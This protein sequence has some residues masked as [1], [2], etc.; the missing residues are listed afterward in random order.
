MRWIE[1]AQTDRVAAL[2]DF[3]ATWYADVPRRAGEPG[4]AN[5]GD[6]TVPPPLREFFRAAAGRPV[7]H[8]VQN[9][10]RPVG[11]LIPDADGWVPF[12]DENQ[13]AFILRYGPEAVDPPVRCHD[14]RTETAEGEPLS[15]VLLQ[16]V[17]SEAAVGAPAGGSGWLGP[18]ALRRLTSA[19]LPVPLTPAGWIGGPVSVHA[20]PGLVVAVG[21]ADADGDHHVFAGARHRS[22]LGRLRQLDLPWEE[23]DG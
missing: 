2:C 19:L 15:G 10:I 13:G 4:D 3:V 7:V 9:S 8:G 12:A 23:F 14:G 17:L 22:G 16:F 6:G 1:L 20:G 21:A 18:A 11:Q 5:L